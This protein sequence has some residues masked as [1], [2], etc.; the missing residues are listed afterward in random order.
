MDRLQKVIAASGVT[1]RRKAEEMIA[2]G[3]VKVDG[4]TITEMGYQP[5]KGARIEI[6][7]KAIQ[8]ES[9][10][11]FVINKPKKTLCTIQDEHGRAT[12]VDL[13][14]VNERI[15][16]VGRL[17]YDT[18]GLLILTNDGD[19]ANEIT[20]PRY[21]I[22]KTYEVIINGILSTEQIKLLEQGVTLDDGM[23]TLPAR[24]WVTNKDFEN[25]QTNFELT[26]QEGRNRQVKRMVEAIG[27]EVRKLHRSKLGFL[28]I[29][30]LRQGEYRILK[31]FEVKQLRAMAAEGKKIAK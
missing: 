2:Q 30:D 20:H 26:I 7:G 22:P 10:V 23:L 4:V 5:R 29:K 15:F 6:D 9:K 17:D 12:V 21:H 13:I 16:T 24:V 18:T 3:R 1:S 8:R 28:T 27:Y 19:F 25:K 31:P 14:D 11:Y